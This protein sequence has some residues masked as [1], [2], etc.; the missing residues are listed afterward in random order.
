MAGTFL[1]L[2]TQPDL[3]FQNNNPLLLTTIGEFVLKNLV[4]VSAGLVIG[5]TVRRHS[6][7]LPA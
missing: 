1:V 2:F 6:E 3:A 5:T 7:T 4:L